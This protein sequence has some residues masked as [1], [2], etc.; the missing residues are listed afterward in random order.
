MESISH[1]ANGLYERSVRISALAIT[2]RTNA[3]YVSPR[4]SFHVLRKRTTLKPLIIVFRSMNPDRHSQCDPH[5]ERDDK[6]DPVLIFS[7]R[8]VEGRHDPNGDQ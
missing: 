5:E 7:A 4:K 1:L 3:H 2:V 6:G 8:R